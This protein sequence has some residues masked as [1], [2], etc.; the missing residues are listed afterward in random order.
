MDAK[1]ATADMAS[2]MM[3]WAAIGK[4][5]QTPWVAG[6][7]GVT[8]RT[9]AC[10]LPGIACSRRS[11]GGTSAAARC[12]KGIED[13]E[14]NGPRA[15]ERSMDRL[16][17]ARVQCGR[18]VRGRVGCL[19]S[20][21]QIERISRTRCKRT[22]RRTVACKWRS[23]TIARAIQS[24]MH[25]GAIFLDSL[26][27]QMGDEKFFKLMRDYF[28]ANTTKRGDGAVVSRCGRREVRDAAPKR[29]ADICRARH[30]RSRPVPR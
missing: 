17:F 9:T 13:A 11:S 22:G 5:N 20:R 16:D 15:E 7:R 3:V 21:S 27:V 14:S 6:D 1:V 24:E 12:G 2:R 23:L 30:P 29:R 10:S 8:P 4:P 25:K 28:A 18:L 19:L 26:R